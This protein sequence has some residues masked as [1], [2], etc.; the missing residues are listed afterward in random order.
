M[1]RE[2]VYIVLFRGVGGATQLPVERLRAVLNGAGFA[3]V[4]TYINSGNALLSSPL[5][6][7]EVA[8]KVAAAVREGMAFQK[9][10]LVRSLAEWEELIA[11]NP[12]PEVVGVPTKLHAF[13]LERAPEPDAVHA[14]QA[15]A[16]GTERFVVKGRSLYLHAPDGMGR[17][18]FAPK[19]EPTLQ[20]A[21]TAR[22]WRT[23]LA[24]QERAAAIP[25]N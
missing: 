3:N 11:G 24:L 25:L 15:K 13:A 7:E 10:V 4:S 8:R 6:A 9:S 1:R 5:G 21:M 14:L 23:V 17:S 2:T 18:L 16:V 19:I 20:V 22:N 12:Y